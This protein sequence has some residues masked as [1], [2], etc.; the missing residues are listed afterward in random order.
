[1]S[2]EVSQAFVTVLQ[3]IT[4]NIGEYVENN[5]REA[6]EYMKS[7]A[8][9]I[10]EYKFSIALLWEIVAAALLVLG[11]IFLIVSLVKD[12]E[13]FKWVGIFMMAVAALIAIYNGYT[14]IECRT[15]PEK[16]VIDYIQEVY[17]NNK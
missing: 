12:D 5:G 1:M 2:T 14:I 4:K 16:T 13:T 15:F 17:N 3:Y 6:T 11:I 10:V 9:N 7:L 8:S